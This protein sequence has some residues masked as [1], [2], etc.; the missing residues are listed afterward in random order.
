[1]PVALL[2]AAAVAAGVTGSASGQGETTVVQN[3]CLGPDAAKLLCPN[4]RMHPPADLSIST[5]RT[6]R[7]L[8]HATNSI[9]SRGEGPAELR[10]K[11]NG[12]HYMTADQRVL[13][14]GG[15][16]RTLSTP[17]FLGFK[18]IPGQGGYWKFKDAAVFEMWRLDS[19]N[20]P[21]A[22]VAT[23]PKQYYCLRDLFRT[24]PQMAGSPP[25]RV[26]PKCNQDKNRDSVTLGTSIGWSDV[27]PASYNE[28]Y[29]DITGLKGRFGFFHIADP[30]NGIWENN[31]DDNAAMT[32]VSLPS[33]K[34]LGTRGPMPRP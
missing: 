6:G 25:A 16:R 8:L 21:I 10:G 2:V 32:I 23:G 20:T 28:Q 18:H 15:G 4:L 22:K 14:K 5:T 19:K 1:M 24:A 3:P 9:D 31:E 26:Y 33:G 29:I 11:R 7:R 12:R 30:K 34:V 27:Y 13:L 17:A